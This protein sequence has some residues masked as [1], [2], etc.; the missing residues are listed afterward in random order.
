MLTSGI[1]FKILPLGGVLQ[2]GSRRNKG[3]HEHL[4]VHYA[5]DVPPQMHYSILSTFYIYV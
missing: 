2:V 3:G 1:Y 5:G 4:W